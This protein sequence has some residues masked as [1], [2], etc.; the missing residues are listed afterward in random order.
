MSRFSSITADLLARKGEAR[1]WSGLG[2]DMAKNPCE[3]ETQLTKLP[4]A[5]AQRKCT[6]RMSRY[7]Y[8]RLGILAVKQ[9]TSRQR[10]LQEAIGRLFIGMTADFG[11]SCA[12]LGAAKSE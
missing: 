4:P 7:D 10:L 1:P 8:E 5:L 6:V 2:V 9:G 12:C 11:S 3:W